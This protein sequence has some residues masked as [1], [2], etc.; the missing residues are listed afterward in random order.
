MANHKKVH[1]NTL[2]YTQNVLSIVTS[3]YH[4]LHVFKMRFGFKVSRFQ[5]SSMVRF[6]R[7]DPMGSGSS[8][9]SAKLSLRAR[10]VASSL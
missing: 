5:D 7:I 6:L 1:L 8:L 3:F 10:R 4:D 2:K 9:T